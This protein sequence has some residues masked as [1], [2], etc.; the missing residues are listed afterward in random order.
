MDRP[1]FTASL[2]V[3]AGGRGV[4]GGPEAG[5]ALVGAPPH[6]DVFRLGANCPL[7]PGHRARER[8]RG[9]GRRRL[10]RDPLRG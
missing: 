10:C 5:V 6:W 2:V 8:A 1:G 4:L 9:A 3:S 7:V